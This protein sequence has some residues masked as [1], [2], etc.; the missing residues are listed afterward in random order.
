[1]HHGDH[2]IRLLPAN[3]HGGDLYLDQLQDEKMMGD[4]R[5]K[6]VDLNQGVK[7]MGVL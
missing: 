6:K 7:M 1:L 2:W 4:Q 3:L 5:M